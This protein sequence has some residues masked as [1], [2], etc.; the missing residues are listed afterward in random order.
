[1]ELRSLH[2]ATTHYGVKTHE[3]RQEITFVVCPVPECLKRVR[4]TAYGRFMEHVNGY[5][6]SCDSVSMTPAEAEAIQIDGAGRLVGM[7][8]MR[9]VAADD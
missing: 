4:L 9:Q 3:V 1:M 7:D 6:F 5:G 2:R 8:E